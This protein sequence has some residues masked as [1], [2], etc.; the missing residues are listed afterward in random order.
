MEFFNKLGKVLAKKMDLTIMF[1]AAFI[2]FIY[3]TE[4]D[5]IAGVLTAF[6][7]LIM[8][9]SATLLYQEYKQMYS[10]KT[11]AAKPVAKKAPAKK[12]AKKSKK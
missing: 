10:G 2:L 1:I 11:V 4:G 6:F 8:Y 5:L 3:F 12:S 7:A 9:V